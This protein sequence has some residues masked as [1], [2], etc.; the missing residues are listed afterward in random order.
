MPR[1]VFPQL[2]IHHLDVEGGSQE[3]RLNP[4]LGP[5]RA[6]V[7]AILQDCVRVFQTTSRRKSLALQRQGDL[8]WLQDSSD[9]PFSFLW[10]CDVL[11]LSPTKLRAHLLRL[12][13]DR[14]EAA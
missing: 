4:A 11:H 9:R 10:C 1:T 3:S 2:D 7:G 8:V 12:T 5:C 6:L 14:E 13:E